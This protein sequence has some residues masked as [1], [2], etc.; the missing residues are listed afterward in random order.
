MTPQ[1]KEEANRESMANANARALGIAG[2]VGLSLLGAGCASLPAVRAPSR[3]QDLGYEVAVDSEASQLVIEASLPVGVPPYLGVV[4][5]AVPFVHDVLV[6]SDDA[7]EDSQRA[8][9]PVAATDTFFYLPDCARVG[10]R[11]RYRFALRDAAHALHDVARAAV[12]TPDV[13]E[14]P[15]STWLLRPVGLTDGKYHLHVATKGAT[16]FATGLFPAPS[17]EPLTFE[18]NVSDLRLAPYTAIGR[19]DL[20]TV[21]DDARNLHLSVVVPKALSDRKE[22]LLRWVSRSANAVSAYYVGFPVSHALVMIAPAEGAEVT[23]GRTMG[24]GGASSIAWV[25][26]EVDEPALADDWILPHELVH[27]ALPSVDQNHSWF[28]EGV[29]TYVEAMAR[30]SAGALTEESLWGALFQGLPLGLP[31]RGDRGLD[32]ARTHAR[33]YWG[34]ALFCF[35]ADME[36][37]RRTE[38]RASLA[39]A[40]RGI[41]GAGGNIATGW[42]LERTLRTGDAATGVDVLRELYARMGDRALPVDLASLWARLGVSV[43]DGRVVLDDAAPGSALRRS[44]IRGE[45]RSRDESARTDPIQPLGE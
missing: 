43:E 17:G 5:G 40:L 28:E 26:R 42:S 18:G 23:H 9:S 31:R 19:F 35:L 24:N 36:I 2:A 34:G 25:G 16:R 33:R 7:Q 10:C 20:E 14:A 12:I 1:I 6:A 8:W 13:I 4:A 30:A 27:M 37:R 39:D 44:F 38:G 21:N 41:V 22:L 45:R 15:P 11:V 3:G 32:H 29:A